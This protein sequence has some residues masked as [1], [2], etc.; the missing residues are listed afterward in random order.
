VPTTW[1]SVCKTFILYPPVGIYSVSGRTVEPPNWKRTI[2]KRFCFPN[3]DDW[4][5]NDIVHIY[6]IKK[7]QV[8]KSNFETNKQ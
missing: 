8:A 2:F 3:R 1:V 6:R 4:F 5:E 7:K